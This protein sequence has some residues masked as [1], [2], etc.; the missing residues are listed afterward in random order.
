MRRAGR[1]S[2][3][4]I[5]GTGEGASP[6]CPAYPACASPPTRRR[7]H[8]R[9]RFYLTCG[10][11]L[12]RRAPL[13]QLLRW[14]QQVKDWDLLGRTV[15]AASSCPRSP[16]SRRSVVRQ[17][18]SFT[19][20]WVALPRA[21]GPPTTTDGASSSGDNESDDGDSATLSDAAFAGLGGVTTLRV[22]SYV[23]LPAAGSPSDWASHAPACAS[24]RSGA[25]TPAAEAE[26]R[27]A[28]GGRVL[29]L[30]RAA[31]S[32][33]AVED[34]RMTLCAASLTKTLTGLVSP[35]PRGDPT[36]AP[37]VAH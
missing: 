21:L 33:A 20:V 1:P 10:G 36:A 29:V 14:R 2:P 11:R 7:G 22:H 30:R 5:A 28:V 3:P 23:G 13:L 32:S 37:V 18:W 9:R 17:S 8:S 31:A 27:E 16:R 26:V 25:P 19:W 15:A 4:Q 6:C 12:A 24:S 34:A 35:V